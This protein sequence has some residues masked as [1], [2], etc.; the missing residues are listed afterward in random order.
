MMLTAH[1]T[2][3]R[4]SMIVSRTPISLKCPPIVFILETVRSDDFFQRCGLSFL[5]AIDV[6]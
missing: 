6:I 4:S 3:S 1:R 2:P 5:V